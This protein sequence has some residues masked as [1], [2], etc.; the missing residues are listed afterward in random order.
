MQCRAHPAT[1]SAK[2]KSC[3]SFEEVLAIGEPRLAEM[4]HVGD[5]FADGESTEACTAFTQQVRNVEAAVVH[6][7]AIAATVARKA[8]SLE[9]VAEVWKKMSLFCHSAL[10]ILAK[11]KGKYPRC[12]TAELY[13]RV[14]D[15]KL[16]CDKR[17]QGALE[18]KHCLTTALP[19]GLLPAMN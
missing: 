19:T 10:A 8:D 3:L 17:Y 1:V 15:Y 9:E 4:Q 6:S 2:M 18:E 16:A 14:L 5:T 11:L 7:Y 13:D 12:G